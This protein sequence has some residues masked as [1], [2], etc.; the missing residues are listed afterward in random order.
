MTLANRSQF[1]PSMRPVSISLLL[2]ILIVLPNGLMAQPGPDTSNWPEG[3]AGSDFNVTDAAGRK[4]GRWIRV[5]PD[6]T[7]YYSGSFKDDR[8]VGHFTFFR[9][10]GRVLSEVEHTEDGTGAKAILYR[11]D[12][13]V[14]HRGQYLTVQVDGQWTQL[15][16][17]P[18]VALDVQ[19]RVRVEEQYANNLLDGPCRVFHP[20]G[21]LLEEGQ[22]KGGNKAGLWKTYNREGQLRA[23]ELWREGERHGESSVMQDNGRLLSKGTYDMG[24][25]TGTWT[26][27]NPDGKVRSLVSYEGGRAVKEEPQHGEFEG[28]YPSGRPEWVG[29]Y[30]HGRLDGPFTAWHDRGEWV[31]VPA[32]EGGPAP[33]MSP[34]RMG[35]GGGAQENLRR[36][37][38]NQPMK[39]MGEYTAGVKD[40]TW[41]YFDEQG[42]PIRT[43]TWQLGKLLST[44]E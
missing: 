42:D 14:S 34:G 32:D 19:G 3:T 22:Y 2:C 12:G 20:S 11:E 37:L 27:Y 6:G 5:Y 17:G 23:E 13:T 9:E 28:T 21:Q 39:E 25:P 8:P 40:G 7:L 15:K 43:E 24:V 1:G 44:E 35:G 33:G 18:W 31:M 4:Q 36:E 41:R 16:E 38:R 10:T 26:L 29:R 30:A